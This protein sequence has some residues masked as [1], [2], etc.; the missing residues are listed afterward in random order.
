MSDAQ[1]SAGPHAVAGPKPGLREKA[2]ELGLRAFTCCCYYALRGI[3][4][5]PF[6]IDCI[7]QRR[8]KGPGEER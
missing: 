6:Q 7:L 2:A 1:R 8:R 4:W 3:V 5:L